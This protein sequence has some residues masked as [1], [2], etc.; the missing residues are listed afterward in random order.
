MA[1]ARKNQLTVQ[2]LPALP[3][4]PTTMQI[5][6]MASRDPTVDVQ[7][8]RELLAL[9]RE[10][11]QIIAKGYYNTAMTKVQNEV[12]VVTKDRKNDSTSSKYAT[13]QALDTAIRPIYLEHGFNLSFDTAD[14]GK[15]DFVRVVAEVSHKKGFMKSHHIDMPA[16]GIGPKGGGVMSKTHATG[17]AVTYGKR[18]LLAMIFNI[19]TGDDDGQAAGK[20]LNGVIDET[21]AEKL[22][23]RIAEVG[24]DISKVCLA[25]GHDIA[26]VQDCPK[27]EYDRV[28]T[29]LAAFG[30]RQ[31]K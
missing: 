19:V 21:Q 2:R 18:Y 20:V 3:E 6:A 31:H 9:K 7:K 10:E 13:Y 16:D 23:A 27:S 11:D 22:M 30:K 29:A 24:A 14:I 1:L 26:R 4:N 25:I 28:M 17:S 5:I 15:P 12:D 8:M